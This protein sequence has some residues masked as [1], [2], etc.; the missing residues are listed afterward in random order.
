MRYLTAAAIALA[1]AC[2]N[3]GA[4]PEY[5]AKRDAVAQVKELMSEKLI[6]EDDERRAEQ[7]V[8]DLTKRFVSE[9]DRVGK[10]KEQEVLE[11]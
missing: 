9:A 1:G 5:S 10:A 7:Q 3:R 4:E 8:D 2:A 11:F 6:G